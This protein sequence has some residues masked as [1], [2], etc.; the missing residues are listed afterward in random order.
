MLRQQRERESFESGKRISIK[1]ENFNKTPKEMLWL[2]SGK[3][4]QIL[5]IIGQKQ[6]EKIIEN[7]ARNTHYEVKSTFTKQSF[8]VVEF[9]LRCFRELELMNLFHCL[10]P[11]CTADMWSR[12]DCIRAEL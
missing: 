10:V 8:D 2:H 5:L 6:L 3:L 4:L 12:C 1:M 11:A 7:A 9:G